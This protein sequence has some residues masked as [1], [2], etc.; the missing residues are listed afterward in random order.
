[1]RQAAI[2]SVLTVSVMLAAI[3]TSEVLAQ[4]AVES[5]YSP[6]DL[7]TTKKSCRKLS[8]ATEDEEFG[9][10]WRCPGVGGVDV[11][12]HY[13]DARD[14]LAYGRRG[15]QESNVFG[16]A[17]IGGVRET[18]EWRSRKDAKGKLQPFAT[19]SRMAFENDKVDKADWWSLLIVTRLASPLKNSCVVGYVDARA[20]SDANELARRVADSWAA[21][22]TRPCPPD[23][24]APFVGKVAGAWKDKATTT[25]P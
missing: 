4:T 21:D 23:R 16:L 2:L 10:R 6:I 8:K 20:N 17:P 5:A 19:I 13:E 24:E 15:K 9:Q 12:V 22:A 7:Y 3:E 18:M 11:F 14:Y 1:M 25:A